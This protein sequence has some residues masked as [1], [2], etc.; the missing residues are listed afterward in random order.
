MTSPLSVVAIDAAGCVVSVLPMVRGCGAEIAYFRARWVALGYRVT[1]LPFV[2][3]VG[4]AVT[5]PLRE[6]VAG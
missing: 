4:V 2:P 5:E 3:Q 6:E 1:W